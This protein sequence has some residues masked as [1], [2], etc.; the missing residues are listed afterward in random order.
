MQL[1]VVDGL[2]RHAVETIL[3]V[4]LCY[5]HG[6]GNCLDIQFS[7]VTLDYWTIYRPVGP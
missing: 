1:R 4:N 3:F 6:Q 2:V 5:K 7:G